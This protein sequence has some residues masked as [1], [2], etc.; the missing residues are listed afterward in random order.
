MSGKF[1]AQPLM[2]CFQMVESAK[3]W[4]PAFRSL[5][6][7]TSSSMVRRASPISDTSGLRTLPCSAGSMS[8]WM[9]LASGAKAPT[10][11][12]TRS[13]KRAP[14]LMSRS[15]CCMAVMAV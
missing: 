9:I 15:L 4:P 6:A 14:R 7:R 2:V 5:M 3:V 10:L 8:A 12:V 1:S 13:S 11:P